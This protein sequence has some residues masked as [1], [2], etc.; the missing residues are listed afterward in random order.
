MPY[1]N[2][3][4]AMIGQTHYLWSP[5]PPE[6]VSLRLSDHY[7][8][9]GMVEDDHSFS[10]TFEV[11]GRRNSWRPSLKG[12]MRRAAGG[13]LVEVR[14]PM[15]PF[16]MLF[17]AVHGMFLLGI[18]WLMGLAAYSWDL[19]AARELMKEATGAT[20]E[21]EEAE[22]KAAGHEVADP[23]SPGA[24]ANAPLSFD[25]R[26]DMDEARFTVRG[27]DGSRTTVVVSSAGLALHR[28]GQTLSVDWNDLERVDL[29]ENEHSVDLWLQ[30]R[31]GD[32]FAPIGGHG[33][34]DRLWLATYLESRNRVWS[35]GED[36]RAKN[37][38]ER[39]RL[40]AVRNTQKQGPS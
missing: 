26:S 39:K 12:R 21:N 40:A 16:V 37:D 32:R 2:V 1:P 15:H 6:V 22:A 30:T 20:L 9:A 17:T 8:T 4:Q 33:E 35:Q 23:T 27:R 38:A 31:S 19:R 14:Y 3:F 36:E 10:L 13:T 25:A 7:R 18:S 29:K 5:D 34:A 11:A 24:D 28:D